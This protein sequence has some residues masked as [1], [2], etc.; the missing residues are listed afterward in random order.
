MVF[1]LF[2]A[3]N[4]LCTGL[5]HGSAGL[6]PGEDFGV[7]YGVPGNQ[8]QLHARHLSYIKYYPSSPEIGCFYKEKKEG[9]ETE[10]Q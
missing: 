1:Y 8:G 9:S 7:P 2:G 10:R 5:T 4:H 3:H 6:T